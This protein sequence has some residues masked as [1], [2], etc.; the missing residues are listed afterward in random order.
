MARIGGS[1]VEHNKFCV[2]VHFRNCDPDDY[3]AGAQQGAGPPGMH[4]CGCQNSRAIQW[5]IVTSLMQSWV[6]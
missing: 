6:S 5:L 3:P 4:A 1:S 2:S